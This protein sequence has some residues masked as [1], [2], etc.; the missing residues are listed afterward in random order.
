MLV[1]AEEPE[2]LVLDD[3]AADATAELVPLVFREKGHT[4]R[5]AIHDNLLEGKGADGTPITIAKIP[6]SLAVE[7]VRE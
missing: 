2:E 3:R 6:E 1:S 7:L 4:G 5:D